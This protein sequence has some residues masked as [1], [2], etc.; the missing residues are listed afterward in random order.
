[1]KMKR[2]YLSENASLKWLETPCVYNVRTD[3]LYEVDESGFNFMKE[4]AHADGCSSRNREFIDFCMAEGLLSERVAKE[5][6]IPD[7]QSSVPSLRYLELQITDRCNLKCRHCYIGKGDSHELPLKAVRGVMEEFETMQGLRLLITGGEPLLYSQFERLNDILPDFEFRKVLFTN[8][9]FLTRDV[10]KWLKVDEL[11][12]SI[13]GLEQAND[14]IRGSG[15][16]ERSMKAIKLAIDS[17][18]DVSISTMV[19]SENLGDFEKMEEIFKE[20]GIRDWTVDVP[21][22]SGR[23]RENSNLLPPAD[24][25]GR[26]LAYGFGNGLHGGGEGYVCGLHLMSVMPD[27]NAAKCT[28][29]SDDPVGHINDGLESCWEKVEHT[30]VDD[31]ECDCALIDVCRGGCRYRAS[32]TGS[33]SSKDLYRCAAFIDHG[34]P[35]G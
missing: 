21:C 13:D 32:I 4:C 22:L 34:D 3:E 25:A 5:K 14:L 16:Y 18:F 27:G 20:I 9:L 17:G 26:Y 2:Y 11:Q 24:I 19:H 28:F 30:K 7:R 31:L 8:G 15:T 1:M 33:P 12:V 29:Y 10:L 6:R 35:D 23:L